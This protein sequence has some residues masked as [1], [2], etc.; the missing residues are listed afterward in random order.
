MTMLLT[1]CEQ[2]YA[3]DTP[4]ATIAAAKKMVAEGNARKLPNLVYAANPDERRLLN[5]LGRLTGNLETLATELQARF[6]QET[7]ELRQRARQA[8]AEGKSTSIFAQLSS[9]IRPQ[10][11]RRRS[12]GAAGTAQS[13]LGGPPP[14][15]E[16]QAFDDAITRLFA[17]PYAFL[18]ESEG[19]LTTAYMTDEQ[20]ALLW[21]GKPVLP[22]FGMVMRKSDGGGGTW[23]FVLPTSAPMLAP[24]MPKT[25]EQYRLMGGM[26]SIFDKVVVDLT[27]E[28]KSGQ[29]TNLDAV[30]RRAGEMTFM[31]AVLMFYAYG[32]LR[33]EQGKALKAPEIPAPITTSAP[34]LPVAPGG[35]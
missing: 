4:E 7:Q 5:T 23:A 26:V 20:V 9:Q 15:E 3:Q 27:K 24:F 13:N 6:P 12:R 18:E 21:D 8:A 33:D 29:L 30:S 19:K 35:G 28:V 11:G 17:D 14:R 16:R 1:G 2:R 31:P 22:P 25:P 10:G 32:K 34:G